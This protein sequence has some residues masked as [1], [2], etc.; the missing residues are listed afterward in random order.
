MRNILS[1]VTKA[2]FDFSK[3]LLSYLMKSIFL[4]CLRKTKFRFEFE[5]IRKQWDL[6]WFLKSKILI[7]LGSFSV[8]DWKQSGIDH[9]IFWI[10]IPSRI[11]ISK[12]LSWL[13]FW[14]QELEISDY[15]V[16][17]QWFDF[18]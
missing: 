17:F 13:L 14:V 15:S 6:D 5:W 18:L 2:H 16:N 10:P 4:P 1:Q 11:E 7:K 12:V 8:A 9:L 3:A